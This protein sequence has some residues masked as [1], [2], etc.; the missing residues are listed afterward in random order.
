MHRTLAIV[1]V[2]AALLFGGAGVANATTPNELMPT[3]TTTTVAQQ[4]TSSDKTGLWGLV[5]L[6]GLGG[7]AG[8]LRRKETYP[9][10]GPAAPG[11]T[12]RA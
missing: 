5:G 8:L 9:G 4:E 11:T 10:A 6:L 7:L 2:T 3:S 12:P 1:S